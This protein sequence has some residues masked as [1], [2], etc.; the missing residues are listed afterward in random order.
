MKID[1]TAII[2]PKAK[3]AKNIEV[4]PYTTIGPNVTIGIGTKIGQACRLEGFTAIGKNCQI[5]T[6]AVIGSIPQDLKFKK[7]IKSFIKIGNNNVIR[8]YATINPGTG[9]GETTIIGNDSLLMAYSHIAHNC[10]IGNGVII[11]NV[12]TL[13]GHVTIEDKAV[14][15]GLSGVHQFVRVGTLSIIGGCSKA[16]QDVLPYYLYEGQRAT[17]RGLNII[18]LKRA[19]VSLGVRENLKK[20]FKILLNSGLSI[21]NALKKIKE[22]VPP[23]KEIAH[24]IEFVR[25]SERG[26]AR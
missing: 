14:I 20:A 12:G 16:T 19:G 4:G 17:P 11:A 9:E 1:K 3:L 6:G 22:E 18:G 21:P 5:F 8:E 26:I 24:L 23:G 15:S 10:R 2:D 13:A 25:S 7:G